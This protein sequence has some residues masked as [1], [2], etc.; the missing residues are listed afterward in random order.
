MIIALIII[1]IWFIASCYF[2][3]Q[4]NEIRNYK[5]QTLKVS[6]IIGTIVCSLLIGMP[7]FYDASQQSSGYIDTNPTFAGA[8][9]VGLI[10]GACITGPIA[11][12]HY[13]KDLIQ[14]K[15]DKKER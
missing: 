13:I 9:G 3:Y 12:K 2:I 4:D 15:K 10:G 8:I 1:G 7:F 6:M 14:Y 5:D 11:A